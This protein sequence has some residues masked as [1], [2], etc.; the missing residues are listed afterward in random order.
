MLRLQEEELR[1]SSQL[2]RTPLG[3]I[4]MAMTLETRT[5]MAMH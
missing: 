3:R 2:A 4:A 5:T 1:L